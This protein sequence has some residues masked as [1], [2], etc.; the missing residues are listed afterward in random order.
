MIGHL[1]RKVQSNSSTGVKGVAWDKGHNKFV[2]YIN[3]FGKK[4]HLGYFEKFE[5]AVEAR[6][7]AEE[8]YFESI[9]KKYRG[10][11]ING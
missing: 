3:L 2:A 5:D 6:K 9:I 7:E 8:K 10:A 4:K 1:Q 11:G